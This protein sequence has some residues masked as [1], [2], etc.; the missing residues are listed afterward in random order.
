MNP[1][2]VHNN[3]T[4]Y[5]HSLYCVGDS[6]CHPYVN[7]GNSETATACLVKEQSISNSISVS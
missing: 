4:N 1:N 2:L 5:V 3:N 7:F 6:V